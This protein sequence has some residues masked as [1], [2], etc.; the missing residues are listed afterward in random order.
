MSGY[1]RDAIIDQGRLLSKPFVPSE[2]GQRVREI[3][4]ES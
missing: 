2:L 4:D 3:L 1:A